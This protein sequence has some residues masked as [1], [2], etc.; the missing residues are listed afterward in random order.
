MELSVWC[1]F[2]DGHLETILNNKDIDKL[3]YMQDVN[4]LKVLEVKKVEMISMIKVID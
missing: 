2:F 4:K 1:W 3:T